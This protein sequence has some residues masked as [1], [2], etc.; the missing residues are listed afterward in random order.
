MHMFVLFFGKMNSFIE[1]LPFYDQI[2]QTTSWYFSYF[3]QKIA[4]DISYKLS[5]EIFTQHTKH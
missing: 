1:P 2:Q 5:A 4:F 3:S